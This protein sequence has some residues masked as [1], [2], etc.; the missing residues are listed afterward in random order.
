MGVVELVVGFV[1]LV[2]GQSLT[3]R[4]PFSAEKT[5]VRIGLVELPRLASIRP[6]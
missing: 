5:A 1:E 4:R 2:V 6:H 3:I